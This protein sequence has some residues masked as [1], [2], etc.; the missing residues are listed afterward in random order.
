MIKTNGLRVKVLIENISKEF[1]LF[2]RMKDPPRE[3]HN[4]IIA[5]Y[6]ENNSDYL[7]LFG[8]MTDSFKKKKFQNHRIIM[9]KK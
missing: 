8:R 7:F 6:F 4:N 2:R 1:Y 9:N 3:S 5:K